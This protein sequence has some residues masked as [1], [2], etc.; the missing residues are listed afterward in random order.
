MYWSENVNYVGSWL[1]DLPDG[2]GTWAK[3][4]SVYEGSFKLGMR[5]GAGTLTLND[6]KQLTGEWFEDRMEG[7]FFS[8]MPTI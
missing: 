6:G 5:H 8:H 7:L 1:N 2:E 4:S 3:K